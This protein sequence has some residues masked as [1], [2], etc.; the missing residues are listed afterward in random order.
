MDVLNT[1]ELTWGIQ[2]LVIK[3]YKSLE[4]ILV[5]VDKLLVNYGLAKTGDR[6]IVTLGQPIAENSKTNSIYVHTVGAEAEQKSKND[7]L[8]LRCQV[9]PSID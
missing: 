4:D 6:V 3:P 5:Q 1:L 9:I 2:T 8:P 7:L